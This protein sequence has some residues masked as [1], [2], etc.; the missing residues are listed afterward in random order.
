MTRNVERVQTGV[1]ME[2]RLL[3][4]LKVTVESQGETFTVDCFDEKQAG[5]LSAVLEQSMQKGGN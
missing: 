1:R 4:V 2:K 5:E 3:K